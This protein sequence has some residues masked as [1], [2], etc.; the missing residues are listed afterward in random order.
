MSDNPMPTDA[1]W[2]AGP[3]ET[4]EPA[5]TA[6]RGPLQV[7]DETGQHVPVPRDA[8]VPVDRLATED[9]G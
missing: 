8:G 6:G 5:E 2:R 1:P 9:A 4:V 3:A 7:D